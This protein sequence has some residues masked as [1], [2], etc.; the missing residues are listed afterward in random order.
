M[1]SLIPLYIPYGVFLGQLYRYYA[2]CSRG[3]HFVAN[4]VE[5]ANTLVV[6]GSK[7]RLML[8]GFG[9]FLSRRRSLKFSWSI[10]QLVTRFSKR[11]KNK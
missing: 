4:S 3:E 5:L 2:I 1:D 9:D 7:R 10:N 8:K 11:V 6:Q